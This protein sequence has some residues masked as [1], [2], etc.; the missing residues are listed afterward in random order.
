MSL[1][2]YMLRNAW[3]AH[4]EYCLNLTRI[5]F[6]EEVSKSIMYLIYSMNLIF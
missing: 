1:I 6:L 4:D 2:V 5:D 3:E